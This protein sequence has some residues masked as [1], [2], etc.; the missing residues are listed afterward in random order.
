MKKTR[1]ILL[2]LLAVVLYV[3]N[4]E[5]PQFVI[6]NTSSIFRN[7][8]HSN[9]KSNYIYSTEPTL[10]HMYTSVNSDKRDKVKSHKL[11]SIFDQIIFWTQNWNLQIKS[12][13]ALYNDLKYY[14]PHISC[15]YFFFTCLQEIHASQ[16][17]IWYSYWIPLLV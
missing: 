4:F 9:I 14:F 17:W 8:V 11:L 5:A 16:K 1:W 2:T 10:M 6:E 3:Y 12:E 15:I 7:R 13:N